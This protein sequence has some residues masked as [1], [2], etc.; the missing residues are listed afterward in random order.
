MTEAHHR[1][2]YDL[3][4]DLL[5]WVADIIDATLAFDFVDSFDLDLALVSN[6]ETLGGN[7]IVSAHQSC[8]STN[9]LTNSR[10]SIDAFAVLQLAQTA[11]GHGQSPL[12]IVVFCLIQSFDPVGIEVGEF[13][14]AVRSPFGYLCWQTYSVVWC[15][16]FLIDDRVDQCKG[17]EL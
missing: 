10:G 12:G 2:I 7:Y 13:L 17:V 6:M 3:K 15:L 1:S 5:V 16:D 14:D 4:S 8:F 11:V 9:S